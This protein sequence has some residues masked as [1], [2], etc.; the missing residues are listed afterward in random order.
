MHIIN[1]YTNYIHI[2]FVKNEITEIQK[3]RFYAV[4]FL[5]TLIDT[6]NEGKKSIFYFL[7]F[8]TLLQE[9]SLK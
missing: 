1:A 6:K 3:F 7:D 9:F 8:F 5:K 2:Q 4:N